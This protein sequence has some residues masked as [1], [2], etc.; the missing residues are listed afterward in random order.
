[1][2]LKTLNKNF[3][4]DFEVLP[5][6]KDPKVFYILQAM[7]KIKYEYKVGTRGNIYPQLMHHP[8]YK[9]LQE[10]VV[11]DLTDINQRK[12]LLAVM[13]TAMMIDDYNLLPNILTKLPN[14]AK[15]IT[16]MTD[17]EKFIN[18]LEEAEDKARKIIAASGI[19]VVNEER[20]A[21]NN[22]KVNVVIG[23]KP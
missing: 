9:L 20:A 1:M 5:Y 13:G 4:E 22:K 23:V 2:Y 6:A 12:E 19:D 16:E 7:A 14:I 21:K 15:T 10:L 8:V 11:Y 17:L 3:P 18:R